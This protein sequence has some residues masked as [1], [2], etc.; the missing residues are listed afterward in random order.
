M[1]HGN[2]YDHYVG[3]LS[4]TYQRIVGASNFIPVK[5]DII[6][7]RKNNIFTTNSRTA[8]IKHQLVSLISTLL[9]K[10]QYKSNGK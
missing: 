7:M 2:I 6:D 9:L 4:K 3:L 5:K 8:I 10:Q 1:G